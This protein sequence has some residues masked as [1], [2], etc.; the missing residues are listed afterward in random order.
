MKY[1]IIN[2]VTFTNLTTYIGENPITTLGTIIVIVI[3]TGSIRW[4]FNKP[5]PS[6]PPTPGK[7]RAIWNQKR[8]R[9]RA[10]SLKPINTSA[11]TLAAN[12]KIDE[13]KTPSSGKVTSAHLREMANFAPGRKGQGKELHEHIAEMKA[14]EQEAAAHRGWFDGVFN[15]PEVLKKWWLGGQDEVNEVGEDSMPSPLTEATSDDAASPLFGN[16]LHGDN[17]ENGNDGAPFPIPTN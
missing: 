4:Y 2:K 10:Q 9:E 15:L 12:P 16:I 11:A 7:R 14:R 17:V 5:K 6:T 3:A 8:K 13:N 1:S